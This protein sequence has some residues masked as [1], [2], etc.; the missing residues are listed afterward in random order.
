MVCPGFSPSGFTRTNAIAEDLLQGFLV[1][2]VA[3]FEMV[4][5]G[6]SWVLC[7]LR[8]VAECLPSILGIWKGLC[9]GDS[10]RQAH[11]EGHW[12]QFDKFGWFLP[13]L[14]EKP[15]RARIL[16]CVFPTPYRATH[17]ALHPDSRKAPQ[18]FA[19]S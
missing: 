12:A 9:A 6:F 19:C 7:C 11:L 18:T 8:Q 15:C 4:R 14:P 17:R 1:G 5:E 3:R 2:R 10:L 16:P 13:G